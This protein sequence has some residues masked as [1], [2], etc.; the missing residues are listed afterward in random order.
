MPARVRHALLVSAAVVIFALPL[1]PEI[2][3]ARRLVFRDAHITHWPWRR[4]AMA[5][6]QSRQAPFI[7]ASASGGQPLLV[8]PNAVLLYPTL[9]AETFLPPA[10]AF[11]L[12][13]LFP[14][15]WALLGASALGR[16]FGL[17]WGAAFAT[18]TAFA[19]SGM[20]LSYASAF[21][22]SSPAASWLPWC[23]AAGI[24][25]ARSRGARQMVRAA[26]AT[27]IAF[28][29]Q[30]L[31]GEPALSLLT[32]VFAGTLS[33]AVLFSDRSRSGAEKARVGIA[34][35][36][37]G[38]GAAALSAALLLPLTAVLP[39]TYRGQ[40]LYSARAFSA[41]AFQLWRTIEW[42]FPRFSGD[43]GA[44]GPGA[45]WQYALHRGEILYI[46]SATFGVLPLLLILLAALRR[47]F[48]DRRALGL[49]GA[50]SIALLFAFG[51][52]LPFYALLFH[53]EAL[54]RLRYP[55]KFYLVTTLCVALLFGFALES[56]R[57]RRAGTREALLLLA[58][59]AVFAAVYVAARP[60]GRVDA[61]IRPYLA[62]L[63]VPA[64]SLLPAIRDTLR[65]DALLGLASTAVI[66]L[67]CLFR[68]ARSNPARAEIF[69]IATIMLAL[70]AGLPLFVSAD[71]K[72]LER[73]PVLEGPLHGSGRLFV[74]PALPEFNVLET[75]TAHPALPDRVGP[76]AR[77]Q[78]EELIPE[79]GSPFGARYIFEEDPDGSYGWFNDF[80][81][82]VF[83]A[84]E[85]AQKCRLLRAFGARWILDEDSGKFF[86][87]GPMT[88]VVV[89]GRRLALS[90]IPGSLG[91]LR[92]AGRAHSR[93]S[94]SGA[95][96]RVR[97]EDFLAPTDV[98][99]RGA[100]LDA[101]REISRASLSNVR[102]A[103]DR[104][105]A[106]VDADGPGHLLFSRTFF[107][108]WKSHLDGAPVPTLVANGRDLAVAVPRG[109]HHVEIE[110]DRRP[111]V[112]GVALQLA[113][114]LALGVG[115]AATRRS[116]PV[117]PPAPS[118]RPRATT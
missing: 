1:L 40:H 85:P 44:F 51:S 66:A 111:F 72:T 10:A 46:W 99:L 100:D 90:E 113:A 95:L 7:N 91:E 35:I 57:R 94:V 38:I 58:I 16:R 62:A 115:L 76:F 77:V 73:P 36:A 97:S 69:G 52:A 28:A 54:R 32:L 74:S 61:A 59:T 41:S 49:A 81:N 11:N 116:R 37:S 103:A 71:E 84:S 42:L 13:Y 82:D 21:A 15:I 93:A 4:A 83:T 43:P 2:M 92:W 48:W 79:T 19:F 39:L 56:L 88:G 98:V 8:N 106:D 70:P 3:G 22:N 60:D 89:A 117:R 5:A 29:L 45:H 30:L 101:P 53:V 109:R 96:E 108:S 86:C 110:Y 65:G 105:S 14:V 9:L 104:A 24:D 78:I 118:P 107:R 25:L 17:S 114:F 63:K 27:A 102:V 20:F 75:G 87:G 23:A 31:A 6:W 18:G 12:H 55:I 26:A 67:L 47:D 33:A 80:A 112:N 50:A 68:S 64:A 34:A